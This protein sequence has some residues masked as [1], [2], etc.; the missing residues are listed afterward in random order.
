MEKHQTQQSWEEY[1]DKELTATGPILKK[2]GFDLDQNQVHIGG[3][4]YLSS[5]HK[6]VLLGQRSSDR[7]RVVIKISSDDK[8]AAEIRRER[9]SRYILEKINFAYHVFFSPA[10]I[11]FRQR[12]KHTIA[13][14]E[15]IE[16]ECSFLERPLAEQFFLALQA[17]EAQEGAHATTYEHT[18]LISRVFGRWS[19]PEYL[20][21]FTNYAREINSLAPDHKIKNILEKAGEFLQRNSDIIDLY[22]DFLVHWDFVPHN[23]RVRG[24][25][26]YLL[27]HSSLRFGNKYEGWAR[28][29]N[30]MTLYNR[31]LEKILLDYVHQN[32]NAEEYLS[33]RL[34]R[35]FRLTEIIRHYA[36]VIPH[37]TGNLEL[38]NKK[39]LG[40]WT[41]ALESVL[42]DSLLSAE[43]IESY[44]KE[45]DALRS[46]EEKLRQKE[47]H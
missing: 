8:G 28:L 34:M 19:A 7:K 22:S 45:R 41:S 23:I 18:R 13:I 47:L 29:I 42:A 1:R 32:R 4:R 43:I 11:L 37:S 44:K 30:F 38:L 26:I 17:L 35:V 16:Q 15:F 31:P 12:G 46:S 21:L 40:F 33:L 10:E 6:L 9:A 24:H 27:D 36:R 5:G 20:S 39:R 25:D 2:L 3:E 14:T